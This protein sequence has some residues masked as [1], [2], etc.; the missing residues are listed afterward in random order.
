MRIG[1]MIIEIFL[2]DKGVIYL[3]GCEKIGFIDEYT[4]DLNVG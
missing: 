3:S 1:E 2:N 4:G